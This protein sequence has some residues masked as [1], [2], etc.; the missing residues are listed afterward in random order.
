MKTLILIG[1]LLAFAF[2]A[3]PCATVDIT[4]GQ[5]PIARG[6]TQSIQSLVTNCDTAKA[7]FRVTVT[8]TDAVGNTVILRNSQHLVD[9][10]QSFTLNDSY[11]IASNGPLGTYRVITIVNLVEG[12]NVTELARDVVEFQV[13]S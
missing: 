5:D 7:K 3:S 9:A 2:H 12:N 6:Q 8:G 4:L 11:P 1:L 10:S 13:T